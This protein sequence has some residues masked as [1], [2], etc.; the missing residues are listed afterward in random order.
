MYY[1]PAIFFMN[2]KSIELNIITIIKVNVAFPINKFS[3]RYLINE[4]I[5]LYKRNFNI[6]LFI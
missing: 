5:N 4:E 3:K 6:A 2:Q 1:L